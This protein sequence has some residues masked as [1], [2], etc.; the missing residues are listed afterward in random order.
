MASQQENDLKKADCLA[1]K[2]LST[3]L[4]VTIKKNKFKNNYI[5]KN[6]THKS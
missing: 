6:E 1:H 2:S 3:A 4:E 5:S